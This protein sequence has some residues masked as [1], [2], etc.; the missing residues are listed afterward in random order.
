MA[1]SIYTGRTIMLCCRERPQWR[2]DGSP[3]Y[4]DDSFLIVFVASDETGVPLEVPAWVLHAA[5][6]K[7][8]QAYAERLKEFGNNSNGRCNLAFGSDGRRQ[9]RMLL[10]ASSAPSRVWTPDFHGASL[11]AGHRP[12]LV[13]RARQM[14][15]SMSPACAS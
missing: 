11:R 14:L 2:S 3:V 6:D 8:L 4:P 12:Q 7:S 15:V 9:K 10:R 13:L 5:D 1:K